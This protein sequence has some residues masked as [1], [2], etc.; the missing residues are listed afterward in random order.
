MPWEERMSRVKRRIQNWAGTIQTP[1][2]RIKALQQQL[3]TLQNKYPTDQNHQEEAS[4]MADYIKADEDLEAYWRQRSRIQWAYQG[5]RNTS[6][7]HTVATQRRRKNLIS[8]VTTDSG[9]FVSNEKQVR[10]IF[11]EYFRNLYSPQEEQSNIDLNTYFAPLTCQVEER[12]SDATH[13]GLCTLPNETEI[14][15]CCLHYK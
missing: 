5:D 4:I 8:K 12:I 3:L 2:N 13:D 15:M 14:M 9:E 7:L 1:Q 10:R 6:F 11:V